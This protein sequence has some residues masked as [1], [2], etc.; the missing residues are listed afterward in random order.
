MGW[1]ETG[2][3]TT[4]YIA[5]EK[6]PHERIS[7]LATHKISSE[8]LKS[9]FDAKLFSTQ[10]DKFLQRLVILLYHA[11]YYTAKSFEPIEGTAEGMVTLGFTNAETEKSVR[12]AITESLD[13]IGS[14]GI[15]NYL[16]SKVNLTELL[17]NDD[18]D[19]YFSAIKKAFDIVQE[20]ER[21]ERFYHNWIY[22]GH[23][24]ELGAKCKA[25]HK[26]TA[27]S[28]KHIDMVYES[29]NF[30]NLFEFKYEKHLEEAFIQFV[31]SKYIDKFVE[32]NKEKRIRLIGINFTHVL[33]T[34]AV[35][36]IEVGDCTTYREFIRQ[37]GNIAAQFEYVYPNSDTQIVFEEEKKKPKGKGKKKN[38]KKES[39]EAEDVKGIENVT[40]KG[41]RA[42]SVE[43]G[44]Q[45]S[46]DDSGDDVEK[47][48][49]EAAP[50]VAKKA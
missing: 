8:I 46:E 26:G 17:D 18:Y 25:E 12:L 44:R 41:K 19:G 15:M 22:F 29:E 35:Y 36:I 3:P 5:L 45:E 13:D 11:G 47:K 31:E 32:R 50:A 9:S 4:V 48:R 10:P 42:K 24:K 23:Y 40:A 30:I 39:R 33:H 14:K 21:N 1:E 49:A 38:D 34:A 7:L 20:A 27:Y 37:K 2:K 16:L 43:K 28:E 6:I